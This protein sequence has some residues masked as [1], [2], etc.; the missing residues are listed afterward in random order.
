MIGLGSGRGSLP[1][2][3][4][5]VVVVVVVVVVTVP[6]LPL[7]VMILGCGGRELFLVLLALVVLLLFVVPG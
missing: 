7:F 2:L 3:L 6:S 5:V 1:G 4:D